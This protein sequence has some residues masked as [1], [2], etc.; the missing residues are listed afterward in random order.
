MRT[1]YLIVLSFVF[2]TAG[3]KKND[4]IDPNT[5]SY[6]G[7]LDSVAFFRT[8][9]SVTEY[10]QSTVMRNYYDAQRRITKIDFAALFSGS[11]FLLFDYNGNATLPA[12]MT[13]SSISS[14]YA[15]IKKH[16]LTFDNAGRIINDSI[17]S[18]WHDVNIYAKI[19]LSYSAVKTRYGS[20]YYT[21][22]SSCQYADTNYINSTGDI[23]R[24]S[25]HCLDNYQQTVDAYYPDINPLYNLNVHPLYSYLNNAWF[26]V[27][28]QNLDFYLS[29]PKY[30][31][32][33]ASGINTVFYVNGKHD[34]LEDLFSIQ[35]DANGRINRLIISNYT[36][37]YNSSGQLY[38]A[39]K[40]FTGYKFFYHQ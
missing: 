5:N 9:D 19:G 35:K 26:W 30:M 2:F 33:K 39:N 22:S 11:Y 31:Y 8:A 3:C 12:V 21:K 18:Y 32:K 38:L 7:A 23:E 15:Y 20:N 40:F 14:N 16:L 25:H 37:S 4:T 1:L 36:Y 34:W 17:E 13:D 29:E 27:G 10:D 6:P 24:I 28:I